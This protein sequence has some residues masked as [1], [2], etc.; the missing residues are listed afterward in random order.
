MWNR[1]RDVNNERH[2]VTVQLGREKTC[3]TDMN[4]PTGVLCHTDRTDTRVVATADRGPQYQRQLIDQG[5]RGQT[6]APDQPPSA[7]KTF[8]N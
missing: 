4:G 7:L 1:A 6:S 3:T 8:V 5:G 2:H